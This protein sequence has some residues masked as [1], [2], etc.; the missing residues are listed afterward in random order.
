MSDITKGTP[1]QDPLIPGT[2]DQNTWA[3]HYAKYGAGGFLIVAD[4][5]E[6]D[7]ISAERRINKMI[8]N[9]ATG[10]FNHYDGTAWIET[11]VGNATSDP[12]LL[13]E[14]AKNKADIARLKT[15]TAQQ[16]TE[17]YSFRGKSAPTLP[18]SKRGYYMSFYALADN[19]EEIDIPAGL[20][21]NTVICVNNEDRNN[22]IKIVAQPG[23][24]IGPVSAT[25]IAVSVY[26]MAFLVKDKD[27][28]VIAF[29]GIIPAD[30][31]SLISDIKSK[32]PI[33]AS[34]LTM[35]EI[36]SQLKDRL[37]TFSEIQNEFT[38]QLHT[39]PDIL[40]EVDDAGFQKNSA[41][42]GFVNSLSIP[43]DNNWIVG[44]M[45]MNDTHDI[46]VPTTGE[47]ILALLVPV[48][49]APIVR[50]VDIDG[51][52]PAY[53][54]N[55]FSISGDWYKLFSFNVP[56][57]PGA[58]I[59]VAFEYGIDMPVPERL[60]IDGDD[61]SEMFIGIKDLDFPTSIVQVDPN[62]T[63]KAI[64]SPYVKSTFPIP[65]EE[66]PNAQQE[67]KATEMEFLPPLKGF[68]NPN[69]QTGVTVEIDHKAYNEKH[70]PSYL[71]Y[72]NRTQ[73]LRSIDDVTNPSA[74]IWFDDIVYKNS[75]NEIDI[76]RVN[77][78]FGLQEYD[79]L[80]PNVTG[81]V[82]YYVGFKLAVTFP[83]E[84]DGKI[85]I[86][87]WD[88]TTDDVAID[89]N[90]EPI[91]NSINVVQGQVIPA[92]ITDGVLNAKGLTYYKFKV[93]STCGKIN[94]AARDTGMTGMIIQS[95]N[96]DEKT[97]PAF[98]QWCKDTQ[99]NPVVSVLK[100]GE[101]MSMPSIENLKADGLTDSKTHPADYNI[102]TI[103]G[104]HLY[105]KQEFVSK[106]DETNKIIYFDDSTFISFGMETDYSV[107]KILR[108]SKVKVKAGIVPASPDMIL[109]ALSYVGDPDYFLAYPVIRGINPDGSR[110][111]NNGW[112]EIDSIPIAQNAA[113][114]L[115]VQDVEHEFDIPSD[116]NNLSFM[117]IPAKETGTQLGLKSFSVE[118][119]GNFTQ[120]YNI[121]HKTF[122]SVMY[123]T[124]S[125]RISGDVGTGL[126]PVY[127]HPT[128]VPIFELTGTTTDVEGNG[129]VSWNGT[130]NNYEFHEAGNYLIT[131]NMAL[132]GND[133]KYSNTRFFASILKSDGS[134]KEDVKS[135]RRLFTLPD[136]R[137]TR[138][139]TATF[140]VSVEKNEKID[141]FCLCD[142]ASDVNFAFLK[143]TVYHPNVA[144]AVTFVYLPTNAG[145][146]SYSPTSSPTPS[147][148]F[149]DGITL[150]DEEGGNW[151]VRIDKD[152]RLT[153][154]KI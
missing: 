23:A 102:H 122:H 19:T 61:P 80:D 129:P 145:M 53:I 65:S 66:N 88:T 105:S 130:N 8:Y 55:D 67:F 106:I 31:N 25:S 111:L 2:N 10:K 34:G 90:G 110:I 84:E 69:V 87:I 47:N 38:D 144:H 123:N 103:D 12:T 91:T 114:D 132:Q 11:A 44:N 147:S 143:G 26:S 68:S 109:I 57:T 146:S 48:S 107:T 13:A 120:R 153:S 50:V 3:T 37:H 95:L 117:I 150:T 97:S 41:K 46:T 76:D 112:Q 118:T 64:I 40:K 7:A 28:W 60:G 136:G 36:E 92:I 18:P 86:S 152:G 104:F 149:A 20:A 39:I 78:K 82:N 30:L 121:D 16:P 59:T 22:I 85:E 14:V 73:V 139:R 142:T 119:S 151:N 126:Y 24:T 115:T 89:L 98:L 116:S 77:K 56:M 6:R 58:T 128:K 99:R 131:I 35:G 93:S 124:M 113:N 15:N 62:E 54:I 94:I 81:G 154:E 72:L 83:A 137:Q 33:G 101:F 127:D 42:Y 96:G 75:T 74:F 138:N 71:A 5:T 45:N 43:T 17:I 100:L 52:Y 79:N 49:I 9:K 1:L 148:D 125:C 4:D 134:P 140:V 32:L 133:D 108:N 141:F 70:S 21:D 63:T 135:S 51:S 29:S 27:N